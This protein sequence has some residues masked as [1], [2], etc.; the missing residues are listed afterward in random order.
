M[1][2][3]A[4]GIVE[5][6]PWSDGRTISFRLRLPF[7]RRRPRVTL[8]TNLE[9]WSRDRAEVE[10]ER[11]M[12]L[13]ERGNWEPPQTE[14]AIEEEEADPETLHVT[15]TRF[16]DK[17]KADDLA[18]K[19]KADLEWRLSYILSYRPEDLTSEIDAKWVDEFKAW[20]SGIVS[21]HTGRTLKARS[22]NM[23]L[24]TLATIL[25]DA[26]DYKLLPA[27]PARGSR[28]RVEEKEK[29]RPVLEPDM[30]VDFLDAAGEWD[31]EAEPA[32]RWG[33]RAFFALLV[34]AGPRISEATGAILPQLD[35]HSEILRIIESKTTAGERD[36][37]L[38]AFLLA[39]LRPHVAAAADRP[40]RALT[41]E[42][43]I[44]PNRYGKPLNDNNIRNRVIPPIVE[45]ANEKRR[46]AGKL[47]IPADITPHAFR[48]T[49]A[50]LC[51]MAGRELDYVMGQIGHQDAR[52]ALEVYAQLRKRRIRPV[53]REL[54]WSLMRFSDERPRFG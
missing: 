31:A 4:T 45:R 35:L 47:L 33:K 2:R 53:E 1:P 9:G 27:N 38:T 13:I 24:A 37:D 11:I 39:E 46:S 48:R 41:S 10:L 52:M 16:F 8:G 5:E 32:H 7:K 34:L 43:P 36:I 49:Y 6:H 25:D 40:G 23:V 30:V 19:T 21:D 51:F 15:A 50:R 12:G 26:V 18:P 54:V 42:S 3:R 17:K 22:I 44:F 20:L 28:R 14:P 29:R